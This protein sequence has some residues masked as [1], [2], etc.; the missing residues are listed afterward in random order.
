MGLE[1]IEIY[2]DN[3]KHALVNY[4]E[5]IAYYQMPFYKRLTKK[6]PQKV[7]IRINK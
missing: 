2:S 1:V 7:L 3:E 5:I 6:C 4:K